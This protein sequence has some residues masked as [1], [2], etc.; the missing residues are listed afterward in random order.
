MTFA[1]AYVIRLPLPAGR[2]PHHAPR[3]ACQVRPARY[4]YTLTGKG[5]ALR[6]VLRALVRWGKK[7]IPGT[8]MLDDIGEPMARRKR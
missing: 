5:A 4:A 8:Q 2:E 1:D 7:H 3:R 6:E